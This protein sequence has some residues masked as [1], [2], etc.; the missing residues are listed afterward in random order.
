[1][2]ISVNLRR[3]LDRKQWEMCNYAPVSS[4]AGSFV[5]SSNLPDQYQFFFTSAT[6][7]YCYDPFEDG[8][9]TM[10]SPGLV[11]TFGAGSCGARHPWGYR[12]F[13][14]AG[15]TT[16]MTTN[17]NIQRNLKGY[18]VRFI[19]GPNAGVVATIKS[20]TTG[21]NSIIT[22]DST[23]GTAVTTASEF[24]MLTGR[25][26]VLCA[27]S[28]SAGSFKYYDVATNTW[29]NAGAPA[30][31]SVG[32]DARLVV[33]P[34]YLEDFV[35]GTATSGTS[36]TLVNSGK[37]W[38][39]N[40]WANFQIRISAGTGV[41][42]I[43]TIASNTSTTVTVSAAWTI[44]PD[45]TS[46]YVI[47]GNSDYIYLLGNNAVTL[48]RYSVSAGTWS[49]IT[50]TVARAGAPIAGMSAHWVWQCSNPDW[51]IENGTGFLNGRYI[52]SFRGNTILDRYDIA[53]NT[54]ENDIAWAPKT[55]SMATGTG[56]TYIGDYLYIMQSSPAGRVL[57][58]N[59]PEQRMEPFNQLWYAQGTT[60]VGDR[61][62]DTS[63]TEGGTT[64]RWL[65]FITHSQNTLFR[66]MII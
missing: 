38:A 40:Q 13:P 66:I 6:T 2:A 20:N 61:M 18:T 26:W 16:T 52:Y 25:M 14:T 54:W 59:I 39:T 47:E 31:V 32:T 56:Y 50:P 23:L 43:R 64:I 65:Y 9:M 53:A 58:Y 44:T 7:A 36:T 10:P 29:N 21:A 33:T 17:Q 46:Q 12:G 34:G 1:M 11:G 48:Y 5:V 8:W 62:F 55:D 24:I 3:L 45:A 63:I 30:P 41:G 28:T 35:T 51:Q 57:K 27:G 4:T 60:L 42:Q 49:T 22:F 19:A 37:T 15:T